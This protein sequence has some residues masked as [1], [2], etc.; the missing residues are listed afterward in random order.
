MDCFA[1]ISS[2]EVKS[3]A[4]KTMRLAGART[5]LVRSR[6]RRRPFE[7]CLEF[8]R[9][10][11]RR[12]RG[13]RRRD[14]RTAAGTLPAP[15]DARRAAASAAETSASAEGVEVMTSMF[16]SASWSRRTAS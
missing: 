9:R 11:R 8:V 10:R 12:R 3:A 6:R 1:S 16:E 2:A 4:P 15:A 14:R 13:G 7:K 5:A